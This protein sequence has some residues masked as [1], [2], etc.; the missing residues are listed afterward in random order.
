MRNGETINIGS[1][2]ADDDI[3]LN[4]DRY[5]NTKEMFK[6]VASKLE[7]INL[8][9]GSTVLDV[10]CATG[11]FIYYLMKKFPDCEFTGVDVSEQMINR[12]SKKMPEVSY[13]CEDI[14][15][16]SNNLHKKKYNVVTCIGVL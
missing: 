8:G 6:Y 11:E 9:S 3:Y 1:R 13:F 2:I 16:K 7:N 5:E 15:K 10:G 12:A 4:E 14:L